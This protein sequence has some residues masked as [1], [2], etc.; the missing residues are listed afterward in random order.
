MIISHLIGLLG[1]ARDQVR[2]HVSHGFFE[3]WVDVHGKIVR[4]VSC[5][6]DIAAALVAGRVS[7][8]VVTAGA[9]E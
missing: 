5:S 2:G 4:D 9:S 1:G 7:S 8:R 6:V 3:S